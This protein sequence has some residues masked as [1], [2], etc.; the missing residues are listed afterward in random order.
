VARRSLL[1]ELI[2]IANVTKGKEDYVID[3][4]PVG[5]DFDPER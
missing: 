2:A 5:E 4:S 1:V 3:L